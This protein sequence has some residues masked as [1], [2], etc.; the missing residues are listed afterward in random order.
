MGS[1]LLARARPRPAAR[2]RRAGPGQRRWPEGDGASGEGPAAGGGGTMAWTDRVLR[3]KRSRA[4]RP[5]HERRRRRREEQ[6]RDGPA[7][8][9]SIRVGVGAPGSGRVWHHGRRPRG[10]RL[11]DGRQM[12][13]EPPTEAP[14][15]PAPE[16]IEPTVDPSG[17]AADAEPVGDAGAD[18]PVVDEPT[19]DEPP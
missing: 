14:G 8:D 4:G 13:D 19:M 7:H 11:G 16:P 9:G 2:P 3:G 5:D 1:P 6:S 10:W 18:E 15:A 12:T 17:P